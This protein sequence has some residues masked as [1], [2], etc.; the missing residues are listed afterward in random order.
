[1][2]SRTHARRLVFKGTHPKL[3]TGKEYTIF[4]YAEACGKNYKRLH[5]KLSRYE[6]VSDKMLEEYIPRTLPSR[7]ETSSQVC[8]QAWLSR[9][10]RS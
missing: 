3:Q 1:M 8:S 9:P 2:P 6:Y 5:H 10:L 7:L 4:E